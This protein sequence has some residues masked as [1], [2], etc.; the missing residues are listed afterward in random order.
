MRII[1]L[2]GRAILVQH[3]F[4]NARKVEINYVRIEKK[5]KRCYV[6]SVFKTF[7]EKTKAVETS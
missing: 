5:T 7:I 6:A 4:L 2:F 3:T 1:Y